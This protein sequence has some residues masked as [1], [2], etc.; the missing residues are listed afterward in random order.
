M[1]RMRNVSAAVIQKGQ[2]ILLAKRAVGENLAGFWEFPG[3]KQQENE[4]IV[5]CLEREI[6]EEL[7]VRI[8]AG[9]IFAESPHVYEKGAI[10]LVAIEARLRSEDFRLSVHDEIKWVPIKDLMRLRLSPADIPIAQ[11]IVEGCGNG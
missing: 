7:N 1:H 11:K 10:N 4:T 5:E 2:T 3:G 9:G 6:F 8:D